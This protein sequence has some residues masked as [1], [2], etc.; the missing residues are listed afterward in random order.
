MRTKLFSCF[1][2]IGLLMLLAESAVAKDRIPGRIVAARVQGDVYVTD[3]VTKISAPLAEHGET[4]QGSI[5]TTGKGASVILVFS[6]GSTINLGEDSVLDIAEFLQDPFAAPMEA[7]TVTAEPTTSITRL[8][9]TRG[10]LVGKVAKLDLKHGSRFDVATPVGAAGI[11]GTIFR[12]IF[13]P[14]PITGKATFSFVTLE[15]RVALTVSA[16]S[17][18][19]PTVDVT[20][21][22]EIVLTANVTTDASGNLT[23]TLLPT[24]RSIAP[25]TASDASIAEVTASAAAI[26]QAV[27][28]VVT[29]SPSA[30]NS[31]GTKTQSVTTTTS[32]LTITP[33]VISPSH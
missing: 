20:S 6:N 24:T 26:A 2:I 11:R 14:D 23:V 9:L 19:L 18:N 5:V 31:S 3:K 7:A 10:E 33:T 29:P 32:V 1:L 30:S 16:G 12:I 13:K 25:T 22:K 27:I 21:S 28:N 15:G 4:T 17:V 8:T